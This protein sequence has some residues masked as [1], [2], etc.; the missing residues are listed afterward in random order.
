MSGRVVSFR[1]VVVGVERL[2]EVDGEALCI[3]GSAGDF[4]G[5]FYLVA[6]KDVLEES[7]LRGMGRAISGLG[8]IVSV[9]PLVIKYAGEGSAERSQSAEGSS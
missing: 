6:P 7:A 4:E 2:E 8:V 1:G 3:A 5:L 9:E